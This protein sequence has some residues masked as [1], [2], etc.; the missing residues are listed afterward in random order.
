[1]LNAV[2]QGPEECWMNYPI[3]PKGRRWLAGGAVLLLP[4]LA[5]AA[6]PPPGPGAC[7]G[8]GGP[9]PDGPMAHHPGPPGPMFDDARPPPFLFD[10]ALNEEQQDKVF[11]ILHAAAPTLREQMKAERK[12]REAL[13]ELVKSAQFSDSTAASLAQ[14]QGKAESQMALLRTRMEHDVYAVLT[15]DQ[16]AKINTQPQEWPEPRG[17]GPP[18]H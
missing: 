6:A 2:A 4:L 16:L 7:G 3:T 8:P 17:E 18:R 10:V 5:A 1:M 12:A 9:R 14:A 13:H 15:P 11:A